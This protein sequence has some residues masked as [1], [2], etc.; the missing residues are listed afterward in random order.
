MSVL[1]LKLDLGSCNAC[2]PIKERAQ[3]N[4]KCPC[5]QVGNF[6][7][8]KNSQ[9]SSAVPSVSETISKSAA[10]VLVSTFSTVVF[11]ATQ[12]NGNAKYFLILTLEEMLLF[13][14]IFRVSEREIVTILTM[15]KWFDI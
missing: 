8:L 11:M 14:D 3:Y 4:G 5:C 1:S 9:I 15:F 2:D 12:R 7:I 13:S 6:Q 10:T